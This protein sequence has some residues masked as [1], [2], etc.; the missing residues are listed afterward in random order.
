MDGRRLSQILIEKC[1]IFYKK[2]LLSDDEILNRYIEFLTSEFFAEKRSISFS[3]HTGSKCFDVLSIVIAALRCI[4]LEVESNKSYI[5]EFMDGDIVVY[6]N[7]RFKWRGLETDPF[8]NNENK[9]YYVLQQD[10]KGKNGISTRYVPVEKGNLIKPYYGTSVRTDGMGLRREKSN[11]EDFLAYLFEVPDNE[12]PAVVNRSMIIVCSREY[13]TDLVRNTHIRF[14][15]KTVDLLD[16]IPVSYYTSSGKEYQIGS[17]QLKIDSVLK[18]TGDISTARELLLDKSNNPSGLEIINAGPRV[19]EN[20][21]LDDLLNRKSIKCIN[22]SAVINPVLCKYALE[23]VKDKSVFA[24]TKDYLKQFTILKHKDG[25]GASLLEEFHHQAQNI[26]YNYVVC[27]NV[28]GGWTWKQYK[29]LRNAL[30]IIQ[31]STLDDNKKNK[32]VLIAYSLINLLNTS[33]FSMEYMESAIGKNIVNASVISPKIRIGEL[34][35]L[36]EDAGAYQEICFKVVGGIEEQYKKEY[37]KCPKFDS[38]KQ[39][40]SNYYKRDSQ[41]ALIVP[42]AYY[43]DLLKSYMRIAENI[44]IIT[45]SRFNLKKNY[46]GVLVAGNIKNKLFDPLNC[47]TAAEVVFFAYE[48]E[49]KI[50]QLK[51][52][53][54][55]ELDYELNRVIGITRSTRDKS[56]DTGYFPDSEENIKNIEHDV[57]MIEES[58]EFIDRLPVFELSNFHSTVGELNSTQTSAEIVVT[59]SFL[60][61][62]LILFTKYYRA[63]VYNSS[64]G[65]IIEKEPEN[66]I[67]GDTLIFMSRDSYTKNMVDTIYDQLLSGGRFSEKIVDASEKASYW[68]DVLRKYKD[69]NNITYR[70]LARRLKKY[71]STVQ[72]MAVRQWLSEDSHIVGPRNEKTIQHIAELTKD[73]HLLEKPH[74]YFE[75]CRMV[76]RERKEILKLIGVAITE[77]LKGT[78]PRGNII[79]GEIYENVDKLSTTLEIDRISVL[80]NPFIVPVRLANKPVEEEEILL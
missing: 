78:I 6:S 27:E 50:F 33:L 62:E 35:E 75:A 29:E 68:K 70:E 18:V 58:D 77:K 74:E 32:F 30:R 48:N 69:N 59:G 19:T 71:G 51:K 23:R 38:M 79:L 64:S 14:E 11:R 21:E 63:V 61:G 7:E 73:S 41:I 54:L 12:I 16:I 60:S 43:I 9:S 40:V 26:I 3:L 10:A 44:E 80:E 34:Q 56:I 47:K 1:N 8:Q 49:Q 17:N 52:A 57:N 24:C 45:P 37:L 13:F 4:M 72:E 55:E 46:D 2:E 25:D 28:D 22:V 36:A 66:I 76:R 31:D 67:P 15:N 5:P 53:K 42:K 39:Y 20:T 65:T